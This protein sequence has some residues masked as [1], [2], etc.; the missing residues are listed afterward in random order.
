M[1]PMPPD[2]EAWIAELGPHLGLAG[3]E[4]PTQVILDIARDVAHGAV[5]AGAPVST[6]MVGLALGR[7]G[8]DSTEQGIQAVAD[9]LGAWAQ[10]S[11]DAQG[12]AAA[13]VVAV[14]EADAAGVGGDVDGGAA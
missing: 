8:I 6:F 7:G 10:R 5:R 14:E 3:E 12:A 1:N 2:L 4:V 9:A 11:G 13:D